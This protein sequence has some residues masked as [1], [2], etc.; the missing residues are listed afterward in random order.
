MWTFSSHS[1]SSSSTFT[2]LVFEH[3][4]NHSALCA[5]PVI[6]MHLVD[7]VAQKPVYSLHPMHSRPLLI[8]TQ[9][10]EQNTCTCTLDI[11]LL[12]N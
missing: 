11:V 12:Y 2:A 10:F 8:Y 6:R 4:L 1:L 9:V 5:A 7:D 3:S